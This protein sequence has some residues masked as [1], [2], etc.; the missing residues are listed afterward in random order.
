MTNP[1][2]DNPLPEPPPETGQRIAYHRDIDE[3]SA[4][5]LQLGALACETIPRG[6]EVLLGGN[7]GDAQELIDADDA[8]DDLSVQ[9]EERCYQIIALQAPM[10]GDLR[11]IIT[12]SKVVAE[13]E[14]SA[15]LM[16]NI[17]KASR[18]MYGAEL[19][20]RIR[21]VLQSM[22]KEANKLLRLSLDAFADENVSLASALADI[23]D[24]LDQLNRDI[25]E[26][27]FEAHAIGQIDL[28]AAVQL[29]LIARY[30]ERI[31]DH[32]V[33][34]GERVVY[35]VT[36]W[37]PEHN[38]VLRVKEKRALSDGAAAGPESAPDAGED[39]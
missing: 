33:N 20:P 16:V 13:I 26:A 3:L 9:L 28:G 10:A 32:A 38:A 24:E 36:G 5:V 19:T 31:G 35:M 30:F 29:A 7:L 34:I 2:I 22:S 14:R 8:I 11:K 27:I 37:M 25:V 12:I 15:D 39:G 6:T 18:R 23:D 21:G 1:D 4:G 17:C